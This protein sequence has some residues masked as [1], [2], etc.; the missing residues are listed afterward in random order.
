MFEFI[1]SFSF[2]NVFVFSREVLSIKTMNTSVSSSETKH[3]S[4]AIS[5]LNKAVSDTERFG[6]L[7]VVSNVL[8]DKSLSC[9]QNQLLFKSIDPKFLCRLLLS[10]GKSSDIPEGCPQYIYQTI[11]LSIVSSFFM[12]IADEIDIKTSVQLLSSMVSVLES[13][14]DKEQDLDQNE[15]QMISDII[16]CFECFLSSNQIKDIDIETTNNLFETKFTEIL[17]E[18]QTNDKFSQHKNSLKELLLKIAVTFEWI[19]F[20]SKSFDPF[21]DS[22]TEEF[23]SNFDKKKFELCHTLNA[24]I[25][26][27]GK[28]F[29]KQTNNRSINSITDTIFGILRNKLNKELRDPV[30]GLTATLTEV[31]DGFKWIHSIDGWNQ[32]NCKHF[33]LL[34]RLS[35]IE[36]AVNFESEDIDMSC[37]A[38]CFVIL[39]HSVITVAN[40]SEQMLLLK[41]FSQQQVYDML[42]AVRDTM[43][44]I[45][46][47][48]KR[49]DDQSTQFDIQ[50]DVFVSILASIRVLCVWIT[51]ETEALRE[52]IADILPFILR[53]FKKSSEDNLS[54]NKS[55]VTALVSLAENE[56]IKTILINE[57]LIEV[58]NRIS[59][60]E[61]NYVL[62]K[63]LKDLLQK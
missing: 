5:A 53:V 27:N 24:I 36:I 45:I 17:F 29:V 46:R 23:K 41:Y 57:N 37:V 7:F 30:L 61:P 59:S 47:Y 34:L 14:K 3:F 11:G 44:V 12:R 21:F 63:E 43:S 16:T 8:K 25:I 48:L 2:E 4:L 6:A 19:V 51:E 20:D 56:S 1:K 9:Q 42:T 50:S 58:L 22:I 13:L 31:Y 40:D 33:L 60:S 52:E 28:H 32:N 18:I 49:F 38:N 62:I 39:E 35:C 55:I 10:D 15:N 26:K 54:I